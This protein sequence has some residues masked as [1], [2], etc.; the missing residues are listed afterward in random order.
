[1]LVMFSPLPWRTRREGSPV[2]VV[3]DVL[4]GR[5]NRSRPRNT[6]AE[7]DHY[8]NT[9]AARERYRWALAQP[10]RRG[11]SPLAKS[12]PIPEEG[13]ARCHLGGGARLSRD[14]GGAGRFCWRCPCPRG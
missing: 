4:L 7:L 13:R 12:R 10:D 14:L 3:A 9:P 8:R 6:W 2:Q 11:R 5:G 1:M